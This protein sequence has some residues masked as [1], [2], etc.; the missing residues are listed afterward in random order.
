MSSTCRIT[1]STS[2]HGRSRAWSDWPVSNRC[3]LAPEP[4]VHRAVLAR[5][6]ARPTEALDSSAT[7]DARGRRRFGASQPCR[8]APGADRPATC[9]AWTRHPPDGDVAPVDRL[10]GRLPPVSMHLRVRTMYP[11]FTPGPR[12]RWWS[13]A[14]FL[15]SEGVRVSVETTMSETAY[16]S[17]V[18]GPVSGKIASVVAASRSALQRAPSEDLFG[19]YRLATPT[20]LPGVDP[21]RQLDVYDYD[22][23]LFHG[24]M[25]EGN[26]SLLDSRLESDRWARYV[27]RSRL[28]IAGNEYLAAPAREL[29]SNVHV[30]PSCVDPARLEVREHRT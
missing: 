25:S 3:R 20:R 7:T 22:D 13:F 23:A 5:R 10:A 8:L 18:S 16:R 30:V 28:V 19:V 6:R 12:V 26:R 14:P 4:T 21:P 27:E 29:N 9:V 24:D 2:H 1:R 11:H 17:L 15:E